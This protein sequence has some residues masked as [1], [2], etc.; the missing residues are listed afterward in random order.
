[1]NL[2]N[3]TMS[4]CMSYD[5]LLIFVIWQ[6]IAFNKHRPRWWR[7]NEK[8]QV[9]SGNQTQDQSV[10]C[11]YTL[12]EP[13][14]QTKVTLYIPL[15]SSDTPKPE[16]IESFTSWVSRSSLWWKSI[17]D[18]DLTAQ[19]IGALLIKRGFY[20]WSIPRRKVLWTRLYFSHIA[21]AHGRGR[22]KG[23]L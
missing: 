23:W 8:D 10:V 9:L 3:H 17:S 15:L 1:M 12:T 6:S 20:S 14:L 16:S 7:G 13:R 11:Q 22:G 4:H 2:Y 21:H 18:E 19:D 5:V